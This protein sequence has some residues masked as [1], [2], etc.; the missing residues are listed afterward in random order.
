MK[1]EHLGV[2]AGVDISLQSS[3][4]TEAYYALINDEVNS[5]L[6]YIQPRLGNMRMCESSESRRG[7]PADNSQ[8]F[9]H[10]ERK[11]WLSATEKEYMNLISKGTWR[12]ALLPKGRKT[13]WLQI[14][15][16]KKSGQKWRSFILQ[17]QMCHTRT[18][19][20]RRSGL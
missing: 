20:A 3:D 13:Y 1:A 19:S 14:G 5:L 17:S 16:E 2:I 12:I 18:Y 4:G 8:S 6:V 10:P 15:V 11:K 9:K 7:R